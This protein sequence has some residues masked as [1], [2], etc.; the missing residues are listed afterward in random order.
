[1]RRL[2]FGLHLW[3][4]PLVGRLSLAEAPPA[5]STF[6]IDLGRHALGVHWGP[7]GTGGQLDICILNPWSVA[8]WKQSGAGFVAAP[9]ETIDLPAE[10]G[11]VDFGDVDGD[12][13]EEVLI[14]NR[15]GVLLEAETGGFERLFR[16]PGAAVP[17]STCLGSLLDDVD[18]DGSLD[19]IVPTRGGYQTLLRRGDGFEPGVFLAGEHEVSVDTG[20]PGLTDPLRSRSRIPRVE[21]RD[22]NG[23][24]RIDLVGRAG[25]RSR[26]YLRGEAGFDSKPTYEVDPGLFAADA[27]ATSGSP[28]RPGGGL[29]GRV[30]VH[31]EDLDGD[32][33]ED[34]LIGAG[35][36]L[37]VYFGSEAGADLSRPHILLKHSSELQGAGSFDLNGDGRLD[38][39]AIRFDAPGLPRLVAAYFLSMTL[40]FD[41]LGYL[42]EGGRRFSRRPNRRVTISVR[43]PPL[44]EIVENL[45]QFADRFLDAAS[46]RRRFESGD[47]NG[48]GLPD[49]V[50]LAEDHVLRVYRGVAGESPVGSKRLAQAV[51]D[52]GRTEWELQ[53]LLDF[54][55]STS[56][57]LASDAVAGRRPDLEIPLGEGYDVHALEIHVADLNRDGRGDVILRWDAER[58]KV[59][60]SR[61]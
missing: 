31:E 35:R 60:L 37:R 16:V 61:P 59:L 2:L 48:D 13:R 34:Y 9:T 51:F 27:E 21:L 56:Y 24:G 57:R 5:Y 55:A 11:F 22:L 26:Y 10:P 25:E 14:A 6:D 28:Y 46:R 32:G 45:D 1:M 30:R 50:F 54:L 42:N 18:G 44:R 36:Y 43:L 4:L 41:V 29:R 7:R 23:D 8:V 19:C 17:I 53:D 40:E 58:L 3:L 39:V 15:N 38:L 33:I 52:S 20:G 12:G 47:L 49:A